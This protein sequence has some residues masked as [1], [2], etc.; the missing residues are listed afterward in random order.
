MIGSRLGNFEIIDEIG[1]GGMGVVYRAR[2]VSLDREVA[3]K[4]IQPR[5]ADDDVTA[6]RFRR[7]AHAMAQLQHPNIVDVIEVGQQDGSHYFAMQYID[8]PSLAEVI[9]ER[10]ALLPEEAAQLAAQ[11]AEALQHAHERGVIHRDIKPANILIAPDGRPV[12]TDFG[13]AKAMEAAYASGAS[14]TQGVIGTPEYMSPEVIRGNPIDGRTDVYSLGVV[15]Y[16]MITGQAPFSASTPFEVANKHL[17]AQAD[18]STIPVDHSE[19]WLRTIILRALVKEPAERF[20][21]AAELA[22]ALRGREV[23]PLPSA[24]RTA[25]TEDRTAM[26]G[27][28]PNATVD[29]VPAESDDRSGR[30]LRGILFA[31]AI[32]LLGVVLLGSAIGMMVTSSEQ[33]VSVPDLSGLTMNEAQS[34]LQEAGLVALE[35]AARHDATMPEDTVLEQEPAAGDRLSRGKPVKLTV[36]L[37]EAPDVV[38]PAERRRHLEQRYWAWL[39]AW[40]SEDLERY[41]S[42]YADDCEIKRTGRSSYG[43]STLRKRLAEDFAQNS[44]ISID[45]NDPDIDLTGDTATVSAWQ[46][47]DSSTWWDKGTKSLGWRYENG[48]WY[49]T[50]ESFSMSSGGRK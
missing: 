26:H 10:G 34:V 21:S 23:V 29:P 17:T 43:K 19:D 48:D 18:L 20:A 31:V 9:N 40:Q 39:D 13:I 38:D 5:D 2:Q 41:L 32:A 46:Y 8:G 37:G 22:A 16:H 33:E 15:L 47:Y 1:R 36:S 12:L 11:V 49:I 3:L 27:A 25:A 45:S 6:E 44:C 30:R 35:G 7:E 50:W 24:T 42:F 14:L 4:V 28:A